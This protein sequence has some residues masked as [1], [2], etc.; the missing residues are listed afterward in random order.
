MTLLKIIAI[1]FFLYAGYIFAYTSYKSLYWVA[2]TEKFSKK[3]DKYWK[4]YGLR[5]VFGNISFVISGVLWNADVLWRAKVMWVLPVGISLAIL[6]G[7]G[8]AMNI[9]KRQRLAQKEWEG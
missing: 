3:T 6:S 9:R 5:V 2:H 7:L 4:K 1:F 8:S